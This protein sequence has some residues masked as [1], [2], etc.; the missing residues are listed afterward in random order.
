MSLEL[1]VAPAA[2]G[3]SA[4][5]IAAAQRA[6][7]ALQ[8]PLI[9]VATPRQ[10]QHLRHRLAAA[11]GALGVHIYTFDEL[12]GS[13]LSLAG[14]AVA[15][16]HT[17]ARH[18]LLGIAVDELAAAGRLPFYGALAARPGFIA[19]L[20][21]LTFELRG[22]HIRPERLS[23]AL[24]HLNAPPRLTELAAIYAHDAALL[25]QHGWTDRAG[26]GWLALDILH[27]NPSLLP[28]A[29][30][31]FD[32]F[33]SFTVVQ[34]ATIAALATHG[35]RMTVLL[36]H[37]AA[38]PGAEVHGLFTE[39]IAR[40]CRDLQLTPQPLPDAGPE[41]PRTP[42]LILA[43]HLFTAAPA[44]G[45]GAA[46]VTLHAAAD[47]A[48]EVR[49]AL[50]WLKER[51]VL[52]GW[53]P[54]ELALIARDLTPYR[55]QVV[56]VAT[57]FGLPVHFAGKLPLRTN[58]AVAALLDLLALMRPDPQS[59][60]PHLP[61]RPVI[62]AWRSP[63]FAWHALLGLEAGDADALDAVA[64]QFV[65]L[66]GLEH[67]RA[68]LAHNSAA[69]VVTEEEASDARAVN[70]GAAQTLAARFERFVAALQ[71]PAG[72]S[73]RRA[74]VVWLEELIG[75]DDADGAAGADASAP[76]HT[77]ALLDQVHLAD[78]ALAARDVAALRVFKEVLRGL[79]W[80]EDAVVTVREEAPPLDY[81][82]FLD[83]LIGAVAAA[84][85]EPGTAAGAAILA[86]EML[87][88][89]GLAFRAVA[90]LGLAEGELPQ[91]RREDAFLRDRDREHLQQQGLPFDL[92]TRSFERE[93]FYLA[94]TRA[95]EQLLLTRPRLAE[96]GAAW[97]PSPYWQEVVR[98]T[99]AE[100]VTIAGELRPPLARVASL[101]EAM[102]RAA[103]VPA[104][105]AWLARHAPA[106]WQR[107]RHGAALVM[108]RR[109]Q[110][111]AP[112]PFDGFLG[113]DPGAL[114]TLRQPLRHWS[115]TRLEAYR[116]CPNLFYLAHVLK[117][118]ARRA[119]EEGADASQLGNIYHRILEAVYREAGQAGVAAQL[120]ALP[121]LAARIL[122]DAPTRERF[123]VTA[124]WQQQRAAIEADIA[125]SLAA[126]ADM[127]GTPA[128]LEAAFRGERALTLKLHEETY[129]ISG[130][131]D[132]IDR[133]PDGALR[134][135]D[136]KLGLRDYDS[137]Q[138]LVTGKRL[139]LAIYALAVE[140]ALE[141]GEVRDG[142]YWFVTKARPSRWSLATFVDATTGATGATAAVELAVTY[143]QAAVQ[144]AREGRFAPS[145]PPQGCPTYCPA[146]GHCWRHR[147][148]NTG[149]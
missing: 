30:V 104:D 55:D 67:W 124:L 11:G 81:A 21:G 107:I 23:T 110:A 139:Q 148:A 111:A 79:V 65:V 123:R 20:A 78:A 48:G 100:P 27:D 125:R 108:E 120:A 94:L 34:R 128:K 31:F 64:R 7:V 149:A 103:R 36:T 72:A 119:P 137:V 118:E 76:P 146:A 142:V 75:A 97:E 15:E 33:D 1:Y 59:G 69:A 116:A 141:L 2:A 51:I 127:G 10:A 63:Y 98:L 24:A 52:D 5:V 8:T 18:R 14:L 90:M 88:V 131:V 29:P 58:P 133:M 144:G 84:A 96:G 113:A 50:R 45:D 143:A 25:T 54:G 28:W 85:Y 13:L 109:R 17:A 4:W 12:F 80:A 77:L 93:Y 95:R 22:A 3:K 132:R 74:F 53:Q 92:S 106:H 112:S 91:R 6:A 99:G 147:P 126:L 102:E 145:P 68:A 129:T 39:T 101:A 16:L 44:G 89:R 40:V 71:P 61:H 46:A 19:A 66:R 136:Y 105:A 38:R 56:Q 87:E 60:A 115:P 26:L 86:A 47:R 32:G 83:E 41:A 42:L 70:R 62:E 82:R 73:S 57:E 114:A 138:A 35:V 134:I 43:D 49:T 140:A 121:A 122:D 9:V 135:I 130:V 117:L 37:P